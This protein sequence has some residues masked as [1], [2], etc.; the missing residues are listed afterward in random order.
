M[1]EG[2]Y[3]ISLKEDTSNPAARVGYLPFPAFPTDYYCSRIDAGIGFPDTF[4]RR[5]TCI[6]I[7]V[8]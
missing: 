6:C 3:K 5:V 1:H 8:H 7:H 2:T 4:E